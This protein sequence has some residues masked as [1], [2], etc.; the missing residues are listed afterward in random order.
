MHHAFYEELAADR[1]RELR[2][3]ARRQRLAREANAHRR[4]PL[5]GAG[6]MELGA[7]LFRWGAR[8]AES[9]EPIPRSVEVGGGIGYGGI[10]R[11]QR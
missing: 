7:Q 1:V 6:M 2:A 9:P 3:E 5:L 11:P 4:H 10:T 8:L